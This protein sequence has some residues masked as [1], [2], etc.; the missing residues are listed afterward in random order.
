MRDIFLDEK[1]QGSVNRELS[2]I[3]LALFVSPANR[4]TL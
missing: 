3:L 4:S 1:K 2:G